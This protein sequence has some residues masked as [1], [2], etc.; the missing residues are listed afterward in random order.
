MVCS[1]TSADTTFGS[2]HQ[3]NLGFAA[4]HI[5]VIGTYVNE[6]VHS[7]RNEINIHNLSDRPHTSQGH[8]NCCTC[9]GRLGY[10]SINNSV[11]AEFGQ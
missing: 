6:L 4:E 5:A 7:Y 1:D 2:Q 11:R 3:R 10:C 9:N 8:T